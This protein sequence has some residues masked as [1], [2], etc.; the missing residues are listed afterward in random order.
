MKQFLLILSLLFSLSSV[1]QSV[2][3]IELYG[4]II[5][6]D[7]D[8][9]NISIYNKTSKKGA[10]SDENGEFQIKA[11]LSDTL[12]IRALQY[13][14]FDLV[15]N[16]ANINSK[17]VRVFLIK[18]IYNLQEVIVSN[19]NV[20]GNLEADLE[21]VK[22]FKPKLETAY[23]A[24]REEAKNT[25]NITGSVAGDIQLASVTSQNKPLVN[26]INIINVVD[27]LLLPL[28]RAQVKDKKE[29]GI[30]DVPAE[31]VKYYMGSEFLTENFGIPL[32]KIGEFINYVES[33]DFD[34]SFLNV[35]RELEFLEILNKK[36]VSFLNE[37]MD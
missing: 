10:I 3:R 18:E 28:F 25:Q 2:N 31:A 22:T 16:E 7:N 4:K 21:L 24:V 36:S 1:A 23:F 26:G 13:Q 34:F 12:Q 30:P 29:K 27:Q 35:G 20:S 8:R 19:L 37:E 6:E 33:D 11:K 5:V 15:I 32:D 14:N 9:E 17:R